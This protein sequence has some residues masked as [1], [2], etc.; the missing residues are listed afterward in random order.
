MNPD[1]TRL[2]PSKDGK[3]DLNNE[4]DEHI[5][6][7]EID[8]VNFQNYDTFNWL[9]RVIVQALGFKIDQVKVLLRATCCWRDAGFG[10]MDCIPGMIVRQ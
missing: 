10:P 2:E 3:L 9:I 8:P 1:I 6:Y 7:R 4:S 5:K